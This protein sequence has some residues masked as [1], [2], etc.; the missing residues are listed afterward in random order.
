MIKAI[1]FDLDGTLFDSIE[2]ITDANNTMLRDNGF[3]EHRVEEYIQWVGN[4]AMK[5]VKASFPESVD[6]TEEDLKAHLANYEKIYAKNI[7]NKSKLYA[8]IEEVLDYL[9]LQ[10]IP[11][12]INTNKP[13]LHTELI[14]EKYL[15]K[16]Q[17][18]MVIGQSSD[19]PKKP[20][21]AGALAIAN[22]LNLEPSN[23]LF[24]GDSMV[25]IETA[26]RAGMQTL[27]VSWGYGILNSGNSHG[28]FTIV[29]GSLQIID[30]IKQNS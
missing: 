30:F 6:L 26:R 27:G 3:P 9:T 8:S 1:I 19:Y 15:A 21:P 11:F 24:V 2:D 18:E 13:Q 10:Q 29:D 4:G 16:W 22:K 17:F 14:V 5:L 25:D 7:D 12:S 20:D 23:I 28:E